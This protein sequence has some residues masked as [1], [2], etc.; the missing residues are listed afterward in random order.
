MTNRKHRHKSSNCEMISK[1]LINTLV[2]RT[3]NLNIAIVICSECL[4]KD[5]YFIRQC[6]SN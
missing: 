6:V 1:V 4:E 3:I 5:L 2:T